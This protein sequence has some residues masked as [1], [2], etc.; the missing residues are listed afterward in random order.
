VADKF[1]DLLVVVPHS[2][3]LIPK[4]ISPGSLSADFPRLL[5]DVDWYTDRLYDFRDMLGNAHLQF[6]YCSLVLEANRRPD[7]LDAAVPLKNRLG[8]AVYKP[9]EEPDIK[10][11]RLLA[12][13]YLLPFHRGIGREILHSRRGFMLDAHSTIAARGVGEK[14]IE[15]MNYQ[16]SPEGVKTFFSPPVFIETYAAELAKR[17]PGVKV[18]VNES[19]FD[20]VYGYVSGRYS[21]DSFARRGDRAP[22]ILQET[23]QRLY[24]NRDGTPDVLAMAAL[25]RAFAESLAAMRKIIAL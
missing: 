10:T 3:L 11:R 16:V 25:R 5:R 19:E 22:A 13:R 17:L 21:V 8:E 15:L 12:K 24:M 1:E 6:H 20:K 18:T 2:G 9:G 4:E 14:Q 23:S 7:D